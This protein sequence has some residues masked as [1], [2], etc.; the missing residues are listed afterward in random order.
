M[1]ID[2]CEHHFYAASTFNRDVSIC[3][4]CKIALDSK[5]GE[6]LGYAMRNEGGI[7]YI[8]NI[9]PTTEQTVKDGDALCD[10]IDK[11]LEAL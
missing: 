6:F 7:Q 11:W 9:T 5:S 4:K 8:A 10:K 3:D 2:P 1:S